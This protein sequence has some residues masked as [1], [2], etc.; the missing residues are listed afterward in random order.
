MTDTNKTILRTIWFFHV[1][2][3]KQKTVGRHKVIKSNLNP[4]DSDEPG[5]FGWVGWM[6]RL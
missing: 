5:T 4:D 6:L 2:G 3:V 1:F